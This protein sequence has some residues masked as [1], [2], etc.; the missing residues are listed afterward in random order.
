M[1]DWYKQKVNRW[2]SE[3]AEQSPQLKIIK[4]IGS[5]RQYINISIRGKTEVVDRAIVD[6]SKQ[7]D[8]QKIFLDYW[9]KP[10]RIFQINAESKKY[11]QTK[12][13]F[14]YQGK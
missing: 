13:W 3:W 1:L 2:G 10:S 14:A 11:S 8:Y 6:W 4:E 12:I 7:L 9:W 5:G